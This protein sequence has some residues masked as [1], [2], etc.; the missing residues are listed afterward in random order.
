MTRLCKD[1]NALP[2]DDRIDAVTLGVSY[3]VEMMAINDEDK[4]M[5]LTEEELDT[6]MNDSVLKNYTENMYNNKRLKSLS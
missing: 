4:I 2:H 5:E 1:R 6:W 3:F